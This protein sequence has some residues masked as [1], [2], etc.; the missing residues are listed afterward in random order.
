[1]VWPSFAILTLFSASLFASFP[2]LAEVKTHW[3]RGCV[4]DRCELFSVSDSRSH[5]VSTD[6]EPSNTSTS[7]VGAERFLE[8]IS[9]S[10]TVTV[11]RDAYWAVVGIL[12]AMGG[13]GATHSAS[14]APVLT[15]AEQTMLLFYN[16]VMEQTKGF[17]CQSDL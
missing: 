12:G 8:Q 17:S 16:T 3:Q 11:P 1:M 4:G 2:A 14:R 15:P 6:Q 5:Y 13:V 7:A 9:C 10:K